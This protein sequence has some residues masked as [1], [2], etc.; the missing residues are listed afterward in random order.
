MQSRRVPWWRPAALAA[1][2]VPGIFLLT[3]E[4]G[5]ELASA[6][7]LDPARRDHVERI[8]PEPPAPGA[9]APPGESADRA[10]QSV[11][12]DATNLAQRAEVPAASA[13]EQVGRLL[14]ERF[15]AQAADATWATAAAQEISR[16]LRAPGLESTQLG[17]VHCRA[18]LCRIEASHSSMEAE[19]KFIG[20]I[21]ELEAF[22]NSEGFVQRVSHG[23]GSIT[24]MIFVSRP[25]H[26]LP[27]VRDVAPL[28]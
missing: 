18:T 27:S 1:V 10:Q 13:A 28:M 4:R 6:V 8:E 15:A 25:G 17:D 9:P 7:V 19:Q 5:S 26:R 14:E 21:S 3:Q 24:T 20:R 22:R 23:D 16:G 2:A 11:R 12:V